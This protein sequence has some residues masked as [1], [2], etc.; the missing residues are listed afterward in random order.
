MQLPSTQQRISGHKCLS[1]R[2]SCRA[3]VASFTLFAPLGPGS[4]LTAFHRE[5][6]QRRSF[7]CGSQD[8]IIQ[9]LA[10]EAELRCSSCSRSSSVSWGMV[11]K[12]EGDDVSLGH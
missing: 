3:G 12:A 4:T 11:L 7:N 2:G 9:P 1:A 5:T 10:V 8:F 6:K